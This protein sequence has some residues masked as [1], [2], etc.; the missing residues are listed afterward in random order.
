MSRAHARLYRREPAL[1]EVDFDWK[2]FAW[3][4]CNDADA[5]V[6]SFLRYAKNREESL[7]V[8]ASFTPVVRE[9]YR[10]GV[11]R[12]GYYREIFNSDSEGYGGGNA[13][14]LGGLRTEPVP[15]MGQPHSVLLR[16]PP[17]GALYFKRIWPER[18]HPTAQ[19]H[20]PAAGAGSR[21]RPT[22]RLSFGYAQKSFSY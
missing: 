14:N 10:V 21:N 19:W 16:I 20:D 22:N 6:L 7:L 17:L 15:W 13:G 2:G 5:G 4:D 3:M 9:A 8:V 18:E 11:P 1:H 12:P